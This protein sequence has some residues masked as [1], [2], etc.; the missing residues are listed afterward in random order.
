MILSS[1]TSSQT[2]QL[3]ATALQNLQGQQ[4]FV[5]DKLA[6]LTP[7][8]EALF[9]H[10]D[11]ARLQLEKTVQDRIADAQ[12]E[13]RRSADDLRAELARLRSRTSVSPG[14]S[15]PAHPEFQ[16]LPPSSAPPNE[17]SPRR[18]STAN[19]S[20]NKRRRTEPDLEGP[21]GPRPESPSHPDEAVLPFSSFPLAHL[22]ITTAP[23]D[24]ETTPPSH[25]QHS[26]PA[27]YT[28]RPAPALSPTAPETRSDP[29]HS[30]SSPVPPV[31]NRTPLLSAGRLG[32]HVSP[33]TDRE[34]E[35]SLPRGRPLRPLNPLPVVKIREAQLKPARAPSPL[36]AR[37][38]G[39]APAPRTR[40]FAPS[41]I[42]NQPLARSPTLLV[43][44]PVSSSARRASH[45]T[46][47]RRSSLRPVLSTAPGPPPAMPASPVSSLSSLASSPR[48]PAAQPDTE[49]AT[50]TAR[51]SVPPWPHE[52][53]PPPTGAPDRQPTIAVLSPV[54]SSGGQRQLTLQERRAA[55]AV[56][57]SLPSPVR[58]LTQ[59]QA[60]PRRA[61][62][63]GS[64][65][66]DEEDELVDGGSGPVGGGTGGTEVP[67][68]E[69][70]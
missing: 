24:R 66:D 58:S 59:D 8:L 67:W 33:S 47:T 37:G 17:S 65:D 63:F 48:T 6:A 54:P 2:C 26:P 57:L 42:G 3:Q 27:S 13:A 15:A 44:P 52:A 35:Y 46:P 53:R 41:I 11:N 1:S 39:P 68:F 55:S 34:N 29:T 36:S 70:S 5:V 20:S 69:G 56:S 30:S 38:F 50:P 9:S 16:D 60:Q 51:G 28:L 61:W 40:P 31:G 7:R 64:D 4:T 43:A 49:N 25:P 22:P 12:S 45:Q 32:S 10:V 23:H 19:N 62:S 18:S 14:T 21:A